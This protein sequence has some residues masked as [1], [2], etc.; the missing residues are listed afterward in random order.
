VVQVDPINPKLKPPG[1]KRLK[2]KCN[3]L[4]STFAFKFNLRRFNQARKYVLLKKEARRKGI[5]LSMLQA[6]MKGLQAG[7]YTRSPLRST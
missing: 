1:T 7:A 6:N 4:L 5:P 3:T 2:L